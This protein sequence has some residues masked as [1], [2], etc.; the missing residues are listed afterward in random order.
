[1]LILVRV[2]RVCIEHVRDPLPWA[3]GLKTFCIVHIL[4]LLC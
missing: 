3:F 2:K 4:M 1:M